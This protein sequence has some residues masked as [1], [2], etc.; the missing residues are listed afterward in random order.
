MVFITVLKLN[1]DKGRKTADARM[2]S[3][4]TLRAWKV[5]VSMT[6]RRDEVSGREVQTC[7]SERREGIF[8]LF[9][10]QFVSQKTTKG[11]LAHASVEPTAL[12]TAAFVSFQPFSARDARLVTIWVQ[13]ASEGDVICLFV[14]NHRCLAAL[15]CVHWDRDVVL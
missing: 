3:P 8:S 13:S 12:V 9:F 5:L 2:M 4:R 1:S 15:V 14:S 7:T 10:S 11:A 6:R